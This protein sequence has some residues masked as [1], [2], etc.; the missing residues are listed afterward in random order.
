[1]TAKQRDYLRHVLPNNEDV[2]CEGEF[3]RPYN[4]DRIVMY[5]LRREGNR[6]WVDF[7]APCNFRC[8]ENIVDFDN[9]DVDEIIRCYKETEAAA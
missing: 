7:H 9:E 8:Y 6:I 3:V 4:D 5:G 2:K 1:M